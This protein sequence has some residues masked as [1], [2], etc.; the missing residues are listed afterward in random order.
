VKKKSCGKKINK[1]MT[2]FSKVLHTLGQLQIS[3]KKYFFNCKIYSACLVYREGIGTVVIEACCDASAYTGTNIH[4]RLKKMC[5]KGRC[6]VYA[7][8]LTI[9]MKLYESHWIYFV[10][11]PKHYL[12]KMGKSALGRCK[13]VFWLQRS[14]QGWLLSKVI[15]ILTN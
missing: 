7:V 10:H 12:D 8:H 9:Q 4:K 13:K 11:D 6:N 1:G 15:R 2:C 3:W 5:W 14:E